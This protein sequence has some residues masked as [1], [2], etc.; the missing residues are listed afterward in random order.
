MQIVLFLIFVLLILLA[1]VSKKNSFSNSQKSIVTIVITIFA[2][3][4]YVYESSTD[5][6]A[7]HNRE[8]VNAFKQGKILTCEEQKVDNEKFLYVSGTQT[9]IPK[10]NEKTLE[11]IIVRVSTC[12]AD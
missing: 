4:I 1:V 11:G 10:S 8:V 6:H 3:A 5:K 7:E 9:F 2:L 12:K